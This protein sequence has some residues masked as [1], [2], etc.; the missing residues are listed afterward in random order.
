V[1]VVRGTLLRWA[2]CR[3]SIDLP[4]PLADFYILDLQK[5]KTSRLTF[6]LRLLSTLI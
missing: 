1:V 4:D 3:F 6:H 5:Q 2:A